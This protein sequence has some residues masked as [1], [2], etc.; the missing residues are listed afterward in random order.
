M[1]DKIGR[2]SPCSCGSGKKFKKC[3]GASHSSG[4]DDLLSPM[5]DELL[6]GTKVDFYFDI[7]RSVVLYS[8]SLKT[9]PKFGRELR[10][11]CRDFEERFKPGTE[12]G[13]PDSFYLNWIVFDNRFGVDQ[14]TVIERFMK[15]DLFKES[16]GEVR[17]AFLELSESYATC[18]EIKKISE[19]SILFEELVTGRK[20]TVNRVG[21]PVEEDAK[22]GDIWHA[23][24]VGPYEDAY[25][26]G[27]PFAFGREAKRDF[28]KIVSGLIS[29]FKEYMSTRSLE[30]KIPRDAFKAAI[31]FWAEYFYEGPLKHLNDNLRSDE[32]L[33]GALPKP[34]MC[35]TDGEK[36][37]FSEVVFKIIDKERVRDKLSGLR[38]IEYDDGNDCWIWSKK[39]NRRMKSWDNTLLG[40]IYIKKGKLVGEVNSLERALRL[41]NKLSMRLGKAVYYESID[42]K[43][44]AT[45]PKPS[46]EEMRKFSE[47]QRR[48]NAYPEIREALIQKQEE[49]YLE[50]WISSRI[51]A[52][53]GRTPQQ[54]VKTKEGRLQLE[55]LINRMEGM[56]NAKPDHM[57][58]MD[59]N[60]L[61]SA[62]GLPIAKRNKFMK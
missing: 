28:I 14:Y 11:L 50:D 41:K 35:T 39:G 4:M 48:I 3:C 10:R 30:F 26:F 36:I 33:S 22:P 19:K 49:H 20:W 25:Y 34:I 42:S 24:F 1:S 45:M 17:E 51:P 55:V 37:R 5:P 31:G 59:M 53:D 52:L 16:T 60:F 21:D 12:Y 29:T 61:R 7:Y 57:P 6:T 40:R 62:L 8:E 18:C 44:H 2:N 23:R 47:E 27:Q 32:A 15:E 56:E 46:P 58:K 54:A 9:D 43:D 13:L 38:G